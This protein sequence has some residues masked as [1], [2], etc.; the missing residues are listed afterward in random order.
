V[1]ADATAKGYCKVV[2]V[3]LNMADSGHISAIQRK[4]ANVPF[5][6]TEP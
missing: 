5:W 1:L 6:L 4:L 2:G 3:Q